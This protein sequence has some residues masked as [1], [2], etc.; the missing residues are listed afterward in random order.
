MSDNLVPFPV[1]SNQ[2]SWL[3]RKLPFGL[4]AERWGFGKVHTGASR[5]YGYFPQTPP[6]VH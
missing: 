5:V 2:T 1:T 3:C 6:I 4:L